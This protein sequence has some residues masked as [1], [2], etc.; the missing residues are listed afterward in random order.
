LSPQKKI[1]GVL[2]I[3]VSIFSVVI[4]NLLFIGS[5]KKVQS[6]V[7]TNFYFLQNENKPIVLLYFGYTGCSY[8]CVT[9]LSQ[10]NELY[11]KTNQEKVA[12]YFVN[13]MTTAGES[14]TKSYVES[15]NPQFKSVVP[16]REKLFEMT[17]LLKV[18][19][20]QSMFNKEEIDHT[21][22]LYFLVKENDTYVQKQVY[23][24]YPYDLEL[25]L[26]DIDSI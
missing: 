17:S 9:A 5:S 3:I 25:I 11:S 12:V 1:Y 8:I 18:N 23:I 26:N 2:L 16:T 24:H 22:F 14:E 19:F 13:I 15:F 21:G 10:L 4:I 7:P 20:T 6:D